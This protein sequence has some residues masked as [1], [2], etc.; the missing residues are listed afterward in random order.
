MVLSDAQISQFAQQG[1]VLV[2]DAI[3]PQQ[4]QLLRHDFQQWVEQ[5]R[6][7]REPFGEI[8]DGRARF[9]MAPS[10]SADQPALRRVSSPQ[11]LS[12]PYLAVMR[13]N[14]ALDGLSQLYGPNLKF[15][16]AK[17]NSKLPGSNTEV[18][19]HQDFAFEPH[20]N[21]NLATVLIFLDDVS[22]ENG[23][24]EVVPGSHLGPLHEHWHNG[25]FTG[26]VADGISAKVAPTA[27]FCTGRAGSACIMHT[28]LL[29]GST[30]NN[31]NAPRTI[32]IVEYA[33]EDAVPLIINHIPSA[34][35]GEVVRGE[36]T[37]RMRAN[38]FNLA[39]PEYPNDVS[40]F[41]QQ[42]EH[43]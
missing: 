5:S 25:V 36:Y 27:V 3:S 2:E 11:E 29:H 8:M 19:Y 43:K 21:D 17:I 28:R 33:A 15:N 30:A 9:D 1:Y 14:R 16:N 24:L 22:M 32:Y 12:A 34:Q 26:A 13:D 23:P 35:E 4:V 18:K 42:A 38:T 6:G 31:S 41:S 39:T 37:G 7:H 40:F 10:H 20:S